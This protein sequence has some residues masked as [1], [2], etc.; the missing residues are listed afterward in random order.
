[1][2]YHLKRGYCCKSNCRHCPFGYD[3]KRN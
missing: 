2:Q 3:P 1:E